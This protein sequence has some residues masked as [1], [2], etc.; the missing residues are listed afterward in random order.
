MRW[1]GWPRRRSRSGIDNDG[2]RDDLVGSR[3]TV[4]LDHYFDDLRYHSIADFFVDH[5]DH[6]D[7][8]DDVDHHDSSRRGH[9]YHDVV[10]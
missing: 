9:D 1:V 4:L 5:V 8:V 2:G 10:G 3:R 7:H 6:V